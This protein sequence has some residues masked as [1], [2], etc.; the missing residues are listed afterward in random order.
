VSGF[1]PKLEPFTELQSG[2]R[3]LVAPNPSMMTGPGTNTYLFG[4]EEIAVLDPGPIIS[5]HLEAIQRIADAPI[6]WVLVTHTHPDHSPAASVLAKETGAELIGIP[7]P[8]GAH[9]D[10][11]FQPD[12]VLADGDQLVS[13]AFAIRAVHTPGHASNH[14]CFHHEASD[15]VFT[16]DHVIDGSTVV[17]NPPDGNMKQYI[18][19]LRRLRSMG[20]AALAPGH[21]E[22]IHDPER[23]IDW[24]IEHRLEREA[25][26]VAAL[27]ANPDIT[28]RELVPHVYKD[29][30]KKLY[31][32][33]ERSLLAHLIKLEE[34]GLSLLANDRW[35]LMGE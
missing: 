23:A 24:I 18:E 17:I 2:I 33:A 20:C 5:R 29:V 3:R 32:L 8:V 15:W 1:G 35:T 28:T 30:D 19:S 34:D 25:R 6:R 31:G 22:V 14:V 13:D 27:K 10:E 11:S 4:V 21:G 12:R 16:G 26:V 7:A 9:Q